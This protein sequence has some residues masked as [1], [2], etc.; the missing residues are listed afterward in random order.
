[1]LVLQIEKIFRYQGI[2][3]V[4]EKES[5]NMIGFKGSDLHT[6][7]TTTDALFSLGGDG[8]LLATLRYACN[9]G[10]A[11]FG[12]NTGHLGFLTAITPNETEE[13]AQRLTNGDYVINKHMMLA[14]CLK[15]T[16]G[17]KKI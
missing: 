7:C 6:V 14:A 12:I 8:P 9:Y 1:M 13:F 17:E 4:L 2:E 3:V 16:N 15:T 5:A 11:A 10:I